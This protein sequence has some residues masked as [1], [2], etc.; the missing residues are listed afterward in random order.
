MTTWTLERHDRIAVATFTRPPR[1]LMSMAAMGELERLLDEVARDDSIHVLVLTGGVP[2]Y[3]VAH[4]DLD[5]LAALGRGEP[6]EGDPGSW[7]RAMALLESMPQPVVAAVNGQ[8]WGGGCELS[9]AC[10]LRV[11]A[12]SAHLGQPEVVVGII[13]GAGGT[14][15]LPRLIGAGRAASLVL[16]GRIVDAAEAERL[17]LVEAVLP[18]EDFLPAVLAWVEP[19]ARHPRHAVVAAKRA[20]VEGLRLPLEDGL[21]LESQLFIECQVRPETVAIQEQAADLERATP[22]DERVELS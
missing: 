1:N 5:D 10:T 9:L 13:P 22:P 14:Q 16:T 3:F 8:A 2:G 19:M 11:A 18:D 6:V 20:L 4:A 15:R 7:A 21:R 17:G 12:Q